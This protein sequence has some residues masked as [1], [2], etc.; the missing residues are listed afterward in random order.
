MYIKNAIENAK[1]ILIFLSTNAIIYVYHCIEDKKMSD[2]PKKRTS[3]LKVVAF[4]LGLAAVVA[5]VSFFVY[6]IT[7]KKLY[8]QKWQDW[9]DTGI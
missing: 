1:N 2:T 3:A 7:A 5:A 8:L 4:F 9:E 6:R